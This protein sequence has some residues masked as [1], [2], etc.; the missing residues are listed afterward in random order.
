MSLYDR[1]RFRNEEA[2]TFT[3]PV[4]EMSWERTMEQV[5][6]EDAEINGSAYASPEN[7]K[8]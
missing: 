8:V 3:E 6:Q 4:R 1:I 5:D 2:E 7:D